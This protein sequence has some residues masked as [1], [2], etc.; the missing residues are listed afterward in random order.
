MRKLRLLRCV[1][2]DFRRSVATLY[3]ELRRDKRLWKGE[4]GDDKCY[5]F[6]SVTGRHMTFVMGVNETLFGEGTRWERKR[7]VIKFVGHRIEGGSF[8]AHMLE[9]YARELG[10]TLGLKTIQNWL[11]EQQ[12]AGT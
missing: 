2:G 1:R 9:N 3:D 7:R 11:Q 4:P 5:L 6:V 10:I 12:E 8:S